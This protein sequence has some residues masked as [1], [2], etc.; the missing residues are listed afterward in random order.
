MSECG[1]GLLAP[2]CRLWSAPAIERLLHDYRPLIT[3]TVARICGPGPDLPD[4]VQDAAIAVARS[5]DRFRGECLP[6]TWVVS[7]AARVALKHARRARARWRTVAEVAD[8]DCPEEACSE[9]G[10]MEALLR[11]EFGHRLEQALGALTPDHR[12]VVV[13]FHVEGLSLRETARA[14]GVAVGTAKSRL[15]FGR[16]ELRRL[17]GP[18]LEGTPDE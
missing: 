12:A 10:P 11:R 7:V 6:S 9:E 1:E 13:L 15:H 17:M 14:L 4:V 2:K 16:R 18:Y 5:M 8:G 3:R